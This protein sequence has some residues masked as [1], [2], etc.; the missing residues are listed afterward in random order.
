[1]QRVMRGFTLTEMCITLA[2]VAILS[3]SAV[4]SF[5]EWLAN[6]ARNAAVN[7]F[8]HAIFLARSEA[9]KRNSVVV[10]CSSTD[11]AH[12]DGSP[13]SWANGWLVFEN[14][15]HDQPAVVDNGEP[16]LFRYNPQA[17]MSITSNTYRSSFA[18]R[19]IAQS[20]AN[21]TI[22]FCDQRGARS[23]RAIIISHTGRARTSERDA[24]NHAL[25]CPV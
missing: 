20:G 21:G 23:A 10:L 13:N 6:S 18:F 12:C 4:P 14:L 8:W 5:T 25:Q 2:I 15:D 24:S 1:M 3:G 9:I 19:P 22:V 11:G 16:I 17:D 7:N